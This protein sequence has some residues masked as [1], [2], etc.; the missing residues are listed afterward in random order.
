LDPS[1]PESLRKE[2]ERQLAAPMKFKKQDVIEA[3]AT[4]K[5]DEK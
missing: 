1:Q 4:V 3:S 5:E 2:M